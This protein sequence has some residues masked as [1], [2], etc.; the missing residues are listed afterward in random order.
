[1]V[2]FSDELLTCKRCGKRFVFQVTEK[3]ALYE[4]GRPIVAP[5]YCPTCRMRDP[6][7]G[8]WR[9]EVK[10]FDALKGYGFIRKPNGEE[11]FFHRTRVR[12]GDLDELRPGQ[13]VLFDEEETR[14]G[15]EAVNVDVVKEER[16]NEE[17]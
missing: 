12:T 4:Q 10:W 5:E 1:M 15:P 17:D 9:G 8:R 16:E 3:R 7:T 6:K 13:A 14:K 2:T 11:I